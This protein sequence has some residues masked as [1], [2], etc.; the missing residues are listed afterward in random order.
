MLVGLVIVFDRKL[1][2]SYLKSIVS[3]EGLESVNK[4]PRNRLGSPTPIIRRFFIGGSVAI[5]ALTTLAKLISTIQQ[6]PILMLA[7]PVFPFLSMRQSLLGAAAL[8]FAVV[9]LILSAS[10]GMIQLTAIAWL[11]TLF[12]TY[13]LA[14]FLVAAPHGFC[15]CLGT[16]GGWIGVSDR[17]LSNISFAL[18]VSLFVGSVCLLLTGS[19]STDQS[20]QRRSAVLGN[21]LIPRFGS[22]LKIGLFVSLVAAPIFQ[23]RSGTIEIKG[24]ITATQFFADKAFAT[25]AFWFKVVLDRD[26]TLIRTQGP[27]DSIDSLEIGSVDQHSYLLVRF[28]TNKSIDTV[29]RIAD[30][31]S[32]VVKLAQ[33]ITPENSAQLV[34]SDGPVPPPGYGAATPAWIAYG[35]RQCFSG[36]PGRLSPLFPLGADVDFAALGGKG[37]V[38][39]RTNGLPPFVLMEMKQQFDSR[40]FSRLG[41]RAPYNKTLTLAS[42]KALEWTNFCGLTLPRHFEVVQQLAATKPNGE[43]LMSVLFRGTATEFREISNTVPALD[44]PITTRVVDRRPEL[45]TPYVSYAYMAKEGRLWN[46]KEMQAGAQHSV[47]HE[48]KRNAMAMQTLIY[49]IFCSVLLGPIIGLW[50]K[51]RVTNKRER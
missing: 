40:S 30:G 18:A 13:R 44:V 14:L 37:E 2:V 33:P 50:A 32:T 42:Y 45:V 21:R 43:N 16:I 3:S 10:N 22:W 34:I 26:G 51:R 41:L 8:E 38:T 36:D 23:V 24:Y 49:I 29:G 31:K 48:P 46:R 12:L 1:P 15:P 28:N 6:T 19:E 4:T 35:S 5:L 27:D 20:T 17:T 39:F 47:R 9:A 25:T 11:S 7:D